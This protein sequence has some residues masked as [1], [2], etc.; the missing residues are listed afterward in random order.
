MSLEPWHSLHLIVLGA[1][2]GLVAGEL[3]IET[4]GRRSAELRRA[5][6]RFHHVIDLYVELPLLAGVVL[7][8]SILLV[9]AQPDARLWTKVGFG[10]G[11]V[12]TNLACV[13]PVVR[14]GREAGISPN[15]ESFNRFTPW[16]YRAAGLGVPMALVALVLGGQRAGWW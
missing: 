4:A 16:V 7:T 5:V 8:G 3:V 2:A 11:A 10:L 12:A 13:Y 15:D 6:A 1:W 14:R 9:D